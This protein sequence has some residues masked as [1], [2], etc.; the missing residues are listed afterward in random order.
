M[1]GAIRYHLHIIWAK[2]E[3]AYIG[4]NLIVCSCGRSFIL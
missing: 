1:I 3:A 4:R 2:H